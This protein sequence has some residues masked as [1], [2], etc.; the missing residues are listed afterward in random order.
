[1]LNWL[2]P[3]A[4]PWLNMSYCRHGREGNSNPLQCPC[5]ENSDRGVWQ[6][7]VHGVAESDTAERLSTHTH[8]AVVG[9][10][11]LP[12]RPSLCVMSA[13]RASSPGSAGW[14]SSAGAATM[15]DHL[16]R[17]SFPS[18]CLPFPYIG[19]FVF[20]STFIK[21]EA[22]RPRDWNQDFFSPRVA[23]SR[24]GLAGGPFGQMAAAGLRSNGRG[25][26][27]L[28]TIT[29]RALVRGQPYLSKEMGL[30]VI[31][32]KRST[33]WGKK[34]HLLNWTT[35]GWVA[36]STWWLWKTWGIVSPHPGF[37]PTPL[38]NIPLAER[39]WRRPG[40]K[41]NQPLGRPASCW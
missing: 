40:R 10:W 1:M 17:F 13:C 31:L 20:F 30:G 24:K 36:G 15:A 11:C 4:F 35:D 21:R 41:A 37:W 25:Q 26:A 34:P 7:T 9:A 18:F 23:C 8:T 27:P 2:H 32:R 5:L 29:A 38:F 12:A 33:D 14:A 28:P 39:Q 19:S 16:P 22:E 6:A 3:G